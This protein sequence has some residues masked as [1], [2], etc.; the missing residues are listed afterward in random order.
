MKTENMFKKNILLAVLTVLLV[1]VCT[2]CGDAPVNTDGDVEPAKGEIKIY[3]TNA[4]LDGL[5]WENYKLQ[6]TSRDEMVQKVFGLLGNTPSS[7]S[8]KKVLP[9]D[10]SI[11]SYYF[12]EDDQL[13]IDF[14]SQYMNMSTIQETLLRA[15]F[16]KTFCQIEG[17]EYLEFY[18]EGVPL[19]LSDKPVGIMTDTDFVNYYGNS[20]DLKQNMK[21][22][23]YMTDKDGKLLKDC[24]INIDID[25]MKSLEEVAL[26]RLIMGPQD[27]AQY[28]PVVNENTVIN[29][30]RTF[31]GVCYVD[32]SEDFLSKPWVKLSDE[33]AVY[34]VV[35][36][37]CEI[38]GVTKVRITING[39]ERK[40]FGKVAINDFLSLKP[41]L[42]EQEKA[43]ESTGNN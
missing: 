27:P 3:C 13:I 1:F 6:N 29:R 22:T 20:T 19:T 2:S 8:H 12:D 25:G 7:A 40:S 14:S 34:S 30:I 31:D 33:V 28:E 17:V 16:V 32:L 43:G 23:L 36:T 38:P 26:E 18:V 41:E 4:S 5:H 9:E 21:F 10:V 39:S 35:N 37:L 11:I 42:I 15:A 24:I